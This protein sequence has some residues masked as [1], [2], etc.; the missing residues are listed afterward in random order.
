MGSL[1][2]SLWDKDEG[3][4]SFFGRQPGDS[5]REEWEVR[6]ETGSRPRGCYQ[7]SYHYGDSSEVLP[8]TLGD[9]GKHVLGVSPPE[10]WGST[11]RVLILWHFRPVFHVWAEQAPAARVPPQVKN[12]R[13]WQS[14]ARPLSRGR[15]SLQGQEQAACDSTSGGWRVRRR[16]KG[17]RYPVSCIFSVFSLLYGVLDLIPLAVLLLITPCDSGS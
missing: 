8:G 11:G 9:G 4:C 3:T 1:I 16:C 12:C 2:I 7:A 15:G 5:P 6:K 13:R 10:E 17:C 14:K